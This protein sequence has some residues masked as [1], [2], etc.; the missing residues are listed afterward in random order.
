MTTIL[1][2]GVS[3][4]I[5]EHMFYCNTKKYN[6]VLIHLR[7]VKEQPV[8]YYYLTTTTTLI[9]ISAPATLALTR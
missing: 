2:Q 3:I 4:N 7:L 1:T 8:G 6:F 5:P 9:L